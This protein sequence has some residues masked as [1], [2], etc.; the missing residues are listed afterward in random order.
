MISS[1]IFK[2]IL[3]IIG[4]FVGL[5][6]LSIIGVGLSSWLTREMGT[7]E[8]TT[9]KTSYD[10]YGD[11]IMMEEMPAPMA[12]KSAA[13]EQDLQAGPEKKI[14]KTG[15]LDLVVEKTS[16][17]IEK[18]TELAIK[19]GGFVS[20]SKIYTRED[21]TQYGTIIIRVPVEHFEETIKELKAIAEIVETESISGVDVTEEYI[22]LQSRLKNLRIKEEQYQRIMK[23]A[24]TTEDILK[25]TDY[26]FDT[27][28]DIEL[29]EGRIKYLENLTDLATV[30]IHLSETPKIEIPI[31]GWDPL[32]TIKKTF[33]AWVKS[34]QGLF[35]LLVG[36]VFFLLPWVIII[37]VIVLIVR[38][39]RKRK[40]IIQEK[41]NP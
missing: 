16:Q 29:I 28:E 12:E 40:R 36:V 26:L 15:S 6:V 34:L 8:R 13:G 7:E 31:A 14:I 37:L 39:R 24:K 23:D 5:I 41:I 4:I 32:M 3:T 35:S 22:D 25:V 17:A 11:E 30:R 2:I 19:K 33:R 21:K 27:R 10:E 1:P 20:D 9:E 18:I 38:A